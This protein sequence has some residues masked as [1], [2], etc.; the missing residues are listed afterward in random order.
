MLVTLVSH[1]TAS[2]CVWISDAAA[3]LQRTLST[4]RRQTYTGPKAFQSILSLQD[5]T[6]ENINV[7]LLKT[8]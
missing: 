5:F 6:I 8:G 3:Q 4:V 1:C 7:F 2:V